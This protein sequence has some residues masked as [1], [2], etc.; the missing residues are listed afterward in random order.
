MDTGL[1]QLLETDETLH[2]IYGTTDTLESALLHNKSPD[3][4]QRSA[5][6]KG[7]AVH[8]YSLWV[9]HLTN[10]LA[11]TEQLDRYLPKPDPQESLAN[12]VDRLSSHQTPNCWTSK[13]KKMALRSFL[14]WLKNSYHLEE[15]QLTT[16]YF[17]DSMELM[18]DGIKKIVRSFPISCTLAGLI[19]R[20]L[21][22]QHLNKAS[23]ARDS[24]AE[25][26]A[27]IWVCIAIS[28]A[29]SQITVKQIH[30]MPI[31]SLIK[32]SNQWFLELSHLGNIMPIPI[33]TGV[34]TLLQLLA[35]IK[36]TGSHSSIFKTSL[37]DMSK[38]LNQAIRT[39]SIPE[40]LGTI[41]F[42]TFL[43]TPHRAGTFTRF[44]KT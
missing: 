39:L 7:K 10:E 2:W 38:K 3:L 42:A 22:H 25:T 8:F 34:A 29:H 6:E 23:Q 30:A 16:C 20:E 33:G 1:T 31:N 43:I 40:E 19:V 36:E 15:L 11:Y 32:K 27:L 21:G 5:L 14:F 4:P 13:K 37:S 17:P 9:E 24:S 26:L 35:D 18:P 44:Q 12:Y 41:G 28:R